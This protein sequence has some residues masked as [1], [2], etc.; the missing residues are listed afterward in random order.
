MHEVPPATLGIQPT[1]SPDTS[2]CL[3]SP[4]GECLV[5][6]GLS[7]KNSVIAQ[8]TDAS[9]IGPPLLMQDWCREEKVGYA[10]RSPHQGRPLQ[11]E[12]E[13]MLELAGQP[14]P[15]HDSGSIRVIC[16]EK[17]SLA[18]AGFEAGGMGQCLEEK[19]F[20]ASQHKK[21]T[22]RIGYRW[23]LGTTSQPMIL[24]LRQMPATLE[25]VFT[26]QRSLPSSTFIHLYRCLDI[27]QKSQTNLFRME[28]VSQP[29]QACCSSKTLG[30]VPE[31][32]SFLLP[33]SV[34]YYVILHSQIHPLLCIS[35]ATSLVLAPTICYPNHQITSLMAFPCVLCFHRAARMTLPKHEPDCHSLVKNP[36]MASEQNPNSNETGYSAGITSNP[37]F[38]TFHTL[39]PSFPLRNQI[40][41]H[42]RVFPPCCSLHLEFL[43]FPC[44]CN[45]YFLLIHSAS[46]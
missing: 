6:W 44:I 20:W 18:I 39:V 35:K 41:F 29:S 16:C 43:P 2:P 40:L 28:L 15:F 19:E 34:N 12:H 25:C 27:S 33:H 46:G 7:K 45:G 21:E 22:V 4:H 30:T 23:A 5:P 11:R 24:N 17:D 9:H 14:G 1:D 10:P 31:F 13:R 42:F 36:P 3:S 8:G 32:L 37:F 26:A 38:L